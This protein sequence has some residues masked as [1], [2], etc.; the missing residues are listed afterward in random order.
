MDIGGQAV[1]EGVMMKAPDAIAVAVRRADGS[2]VVKRDS[3]VSPSKKHKW[4]GYPIIRGTV[5]MGSMLALGM[6]TLEASSNMAGIQEEEPSKFEKW[7]ARKLGKGVDK[8]IMG[9]AAV[10]AIFLSV[11]L[12]VLL[13]NIPSSYLRSAGGPRWA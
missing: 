10:L 2:I 5:S 9:V 11:G 8:I 3:Y 13:P 1:L 6:R 4:M 12:F 7:L